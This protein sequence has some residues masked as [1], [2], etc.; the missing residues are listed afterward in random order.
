MGFSVI[1]G[2]SFAFLISL[3]TTTANEETGSG[4][5]SLWMSPLLINI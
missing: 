3:K 4:M 5:N 1:F 2:I